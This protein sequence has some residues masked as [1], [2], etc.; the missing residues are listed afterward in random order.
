MKLQPH[1]TRVKAPAIKSNS[2]VD[3]PFNTERQYEELSLN[4][5]I[6]E[7]RDNSEN[8]NRRVRLLNCMQKLKI[9]V[10]NVRTIRLQNKRNELAELTRKNNI[11]IL[12]IVDH[13]IC[14]EEKIKYEKYEKL[15][16]I[17]T[18]AW[19]NSN[20]ASS[21]GVG[22]LID[23]NSENALA[24]IIKWNNRILIVNFNGN[25]KTTII[26][27][28]SPCEGSPNAE[29]HYKQ[30]AIATSTIPIY[31]VLLTIGDFNAHLS[32]SHINRYTYVSR[33]HK[34]KW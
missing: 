16:P 1:S 25:P 29:E 23:N 10:M 30:L 21:G 14:H 31:N 22:I 2:E 7:G 19:R 27:Q 20:N 8:K 17:T 15:T 3:V 34:H 5:S 9:A 18:F 26:V 12:G 6:I 24:E 28:Y 32:E 33:N 13:K 11:N 4:P